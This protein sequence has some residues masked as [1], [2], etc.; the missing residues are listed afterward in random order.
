MSSPSKQPPAKKGGWGSLLSGAVANLE[1]RLDTILAEDSEASA[2]QRASEAALK[3][4]GKT[5]PRT[6][7]G[8]LAAG[9]RGASRD[10]STTRVNDRLAERLA[11]A[12]AVKKAGVGSDVGSGVPSRVA[13]PANDAASARAS[14]ESYRSMIVARSAP[15]FVQPDEEKVAE[16]NGTEG[17][18]GPEKGSAAVS[19]ES[20]M[21][22]SSKLP[23][24]PAK[25]S[26]DS[27][28]PSVES[29]RDETSGRPSSEL[30][31]GHS[32]P[33]KYPAELEGEIAQMREEYATAEKQRQ[34][35]MHAYLEKIDALQAKLQYLAK[36]S[37]AAAK[38]ANAE[39]SAGS[40]GA[41]LAE[42][43]EKIAL[44][45]EEGEKLSKTELRQMQT[46]KKLRAKAAE[47]EKAVTEIKRKLERAE[48]AE[49]DLKQRVRR[50]EAAERQAN[51]KARQITAI[52]KQVDELRVDRENASE[53]IR[54]LT[55]QLREAKEERDRAEKQAS[56]IDRN[57]IATLENELEDAQIEKQLADNRAAAEAKRTRDELDR[58]QERFALLETEYK[59]EIRS[60]ES[61]L[62]AMR[63]RAEEASSETAG[64]ESQTKLL[65]QV[66]TLQSQYGLARANWET[67]EGTLNARVSALEQERDEAVGRETEVRR[68]AREAASARRK[69]EDELEG[70]EERAKGLAREL[71]ARR[72]EIAGLHR[73][74]EQAASA[75]AECQADLDRQRKVWEAEV[76]Q[77]FDEERSKWSAQQRHP[78]VP[79]SPRADSP[80]APRKASWVE[81]PGLHA[82]APRRPTPLHDSRPASR[83]GSAIPARHPEPAQAPPSLSR[84]ESFLSPD[85][86]AVPPTPS[87]EM[88]SELDR[89]STPDRTIN[90]LVSTSAAAVAG[91]SVQLVE[92]MSAAVRRLESEKASFREE[93]ARVVRQRDEARGEVV[94]LMRE[95]EGVGRGK[96]AGPAEEGGEKGLKERYE[97][98]LE[99]L[100]EREEECQEL[101]EELGEVKRLYR[102]LVE[103][104]MPG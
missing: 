69:A 43:D 9:S 100:G 70:A 46:I 1:S 67:I 51:E 86:P 83:R 59:A 42:K 40:D 93:M 45:M 16:P 71:S 31:N 77:R 29:A 34:G 63:A 79:P 99:L 85:T 15:E 10:A 38:A 96:Q 6:N 12:T 13:S 88:D 91:P 54:A 104:K 102:E 49:L 18:E 5:R 47:E 50:A 80:A 30:P 78:V 97:A 28:R 24:N 55:T 20:S 3:E 52:E 90:D 33:S 7:S 62:E 39:A 84:A 103:R 89:R 14:G 37:V 41:K 73:R 65:R 87:L 82:A 81:L 56:E 60:L 98:S 61:R 27:S 36:E 64:S 4:A 101:R 26:M 17:G 94:A 21:L 72:E 48:K 74:L 75:A 11:K 25:V 19:P 76:T 92:R 8:N 53:L 57:R 66:E 23:I 32:T 35:E 44:L 95:M 68:K 2:R 22:L 58:Q